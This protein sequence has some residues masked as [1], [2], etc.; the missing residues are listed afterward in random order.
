MKIESVRDILEWTIDFHKQLASCLTHCEPN[1][2]ER[3]KMAMQYLIAHEEHLAALIKSF[4][5]KAE[6]GEL[7]TLFI[8][9]LEKKD[10]LIDLSGNKTRVISTNSNKKKELLKELSDLQSKELNLFAK[11]LA[12]IQDMLSKQYNRLD[13]EECLY[14][15]WVDDLNEERYR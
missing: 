10:C 3:S 12:D 13:I 4:S 15:L 8:E 14:D 9:Y 1:N 7:E 2:S 11:S 6:P 5:V